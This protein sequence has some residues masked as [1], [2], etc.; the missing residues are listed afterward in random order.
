MHWSS[1]GAIEHTKYIHGYFDWLHLKTL[2]IKNGYYDRQVRESL[3][4]DMAIV[5][6][7]QDKVLNEDNG[8]FVKK[9]AWKPLFR[10]MKTLH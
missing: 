8:N 7:A 4:T 3:E 5:K 6:Y 2:S 1:S 9:N 10:K